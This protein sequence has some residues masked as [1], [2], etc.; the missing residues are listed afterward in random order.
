MF[1]INIVCVGN[2]KDKEY[3]A[4]SEE[5][6]KRLQRFA[7]INIIELKEKTNYNNVNQTIDAE[8]TDILNNI[9]I[10]SAFLLD[11]DGKNPTSE[12]FAKNIE[13]GGRQRRR[14]GSRNH[15]ERCCKGRRG[16]DWRDLP[17][18]EE[19]VE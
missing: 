4:L 13:C 9:D 12:E 5:Y 14:D 8:T 19:V 18:I 7:K 6:K 11:K 2:L 17:G 3:I 16:S 10:S 15:T 1:K